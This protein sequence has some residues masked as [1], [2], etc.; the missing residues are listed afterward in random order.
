MPS[1]PLLLTYLQMYL[2]D[3]P[4]LRYSTLMCALNTLKKQGNTEH[5]QLLSTSTFSKATFIIGEK[6]PASRPI[7]DHLSRRVNGQ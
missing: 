7:T 6:P 3:F 5:T 4:F 2:I 1:D